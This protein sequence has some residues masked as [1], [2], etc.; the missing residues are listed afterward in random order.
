MSNDVL[1][2]ATGFL[3]VV[4]KGEK[5]AI[6]RPRKWED[7]PSG[8]SL[9]C[10][11]A[12][13][14][15]IDIVLYN[16]SWYQCIKS[17][18]KGNG[19][20]PT[21][22]IYYKSISDYQ[23]L[24]TNIFLAN[25]AFINNL[26]VG[27]VLIE[28]N[29]QKLL[30][31]NEDG[32]ECNNG[33]FNNVEVNGIITSVGNNYTVKID[34][35]VIYFITSDNIYHLGLDSNGKPDW[36][37][38]DEVFTFTFYTGNLISS[39]RSVTLYTKDKKT[40]YTNA[41]CTTKANGTYYN[42]E[43]YANAIIRSSDGMYCFYSTYFAGLSIYKKCTFSNGVKTDLGYLATGY[44]FYLNDANNAFQKYSDKVYFKPSQ[45]TKDGL[46]TS[47]TIK[48]NI[49][50]DGKFS[51]IDRSNVSIA[52]VSGNYIYPLVP[53]GNTE[54]LFDNFSVTSM[55]SSSNYSVSNIK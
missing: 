32:I 46:I 30:V 7:I 28:K 55:T 27:D 31:A 21:N 42:L 39:V 8:D 45:I 19:V 12:G 51:N 44:N 52:Q 5:G 16:D 17:H 1:A 24:A 23:R 34:N 48:S 3:S 40:Y 18:I 4:E 33:K 11:A 50:N 20:V 49:T 2:Q 53:N 36:V 43:F 14:A 26:Q 37:N 25:K 41:S 10:G 29:G 9:Q 13:E 47:A 22:T 54:A 15:Y 6:E 35:G 38:N